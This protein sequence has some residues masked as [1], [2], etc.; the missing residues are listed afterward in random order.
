MELKIIGGVFGLF[1]LYL[2]ILYFINK[3]KAKKLAKTIAFRAEILTKSPFIS[4]KKDFFYKS[5]SEQIDKHLVKL[6]MASYLL[7]I[8]VKYFLDK[9]LETKLVPEM[10][11]T[12]APFIRASL[13]EATERGV[14]KL[15]NAI[16]SSEQPSSNEVVV[17]LAKLVLENEAKGVV[18][19]F[20]KVMKE[21]DKPKANFEVGVG[22]AKKLK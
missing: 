1:L 18:S 12:V 2:I 13:L 8:F 7:K 15:T 3:E 9:Y 4:S 17:D 16:T 5:F 20:G 21:G 10:N 11:E 19:I 22:I 14:Q 6:P